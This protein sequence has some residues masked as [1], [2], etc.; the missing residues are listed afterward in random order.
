MNK[1]VLLLKM[2]EFHLDIELE[3]FDGDINIYDLSKHKDHDF[4]CFEMRKLLNDFKTF[5]LT[6][7]L[8]RILKIEV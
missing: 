1:K 7:F 3:L 5:G 2:D 6:K 8:V 4:V